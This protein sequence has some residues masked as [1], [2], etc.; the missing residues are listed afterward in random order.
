MRC[1][2][3]RLFGECRCTFTCGNCAAVE[4]F[5]E[6]RIMLDRPLRDD[7]CIDCFRALRGFA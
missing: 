6:A 7:V 2:H 3:C 5:N 1:H 4:F